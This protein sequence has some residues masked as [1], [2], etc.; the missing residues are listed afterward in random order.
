MYT[1]DKEK[2]LKELGKIVS[3]SDLYFTRIILVALQIRNCNV[4]NHR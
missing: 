3:K 1:G 4:E 2:P